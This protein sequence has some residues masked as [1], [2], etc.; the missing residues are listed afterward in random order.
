MMKIIYNIK[1]LVATK[2]I[3]SVLFWDGTNGE[4]V[5]TDVPI[6]RVHA[7]RIEEQATTVGCGT[8]AGWPI[9]A[10]LADVR[11][12]ARS[13]GTATVSISKSKRIKEDCIACFPA[14]SIEVPTF[15]ETTTNIELATICCISTCRCKSCKCGSF[16]LN[17]PRWG[18]GVDCFCCCCI[19][20][21]RIACEILVPELEAMAAA[22]VIIVYI[23]E[24]KWILYSGVCSLKT[25]NSQPLTLVIINRLKFLR[26]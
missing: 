23:I 6:P 26:L 25:T 1:K 12:S 20:Y 24:C 15:C 10:I 3:N 22:P 21:A 4:A 8:S 7:T 18:R 19:C 16:W 9:V 13:A 2:V 14:I 17:I 11:N 5:R